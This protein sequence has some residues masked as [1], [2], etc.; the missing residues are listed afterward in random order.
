M[1]KHSFVCFIASILLFAW[2]IQACFA[3]DQVDAEESLIKAENDLASAYVVVAEAER[4]GANVFELLFRLEFAGALLASANN[5]YRVGDYDMA[6]LHATN[7]SNT[8]DGVV[9]EAAGLKL[10]AGEAYGERLF[11]T[12]ALSSA[13]LS[14]LFVLSLFAWRFF[15]GKYVKRVLGMKPEVGK[16]E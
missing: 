16:D 8:V 10:E 11:L 3:V 5:S 1:T 14:G 13:G 2:F 4:A 9:V 7:C 6:Y 12:A 15:R